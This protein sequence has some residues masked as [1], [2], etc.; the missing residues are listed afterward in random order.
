MVDRTLYCGMLTPPEVRRLSLWAVTGGLVGLVGA[1]LIAGYSASLALLISS[2]GNLTAMGTLAWIGIGAPGWS[3]GS[4][5][6]FDER[7]K[8]ERHQAMAI[9]YFIVA[10]LLMIYLNIS[11]RDFARPAVAFFS[12]RPALAYRATL[13]FALTAL[14]GIILAWRSKRIEQTVEDED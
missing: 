5:G 14:P 8:A 4:P 11:D 1:P 10:V 3:V 6:Q 13:M 7:E 12:T 9:S 2:I